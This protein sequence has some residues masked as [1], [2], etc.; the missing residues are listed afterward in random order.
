MDKKDLFKVLQERG[1]IYQAT[2]LEEIEKMLTQDTITAYVGIDPTADSLHIGHCFPLIIARYLQEAGHK[3]FVVL[4]GA[5]AKIGDPSGKST[6]RKMVTDEFVNNNY[7]AIRKII[8][9][10]VDLEGE[11]KATIVNNAEWFRGYDYVNFM[12]DIGVHFNVAH[13]LQSDAYQKRIADGGLTFFEM[14]Y[15]LMQAYDFAYLNRTYGC[16][17]EFGGSDQW[18]NIVAGKEL[19]R[20]LN[21]KEGSVQ[22]P[23]EGFTHPLLTNYEG[24]KMGKTEKGALWVDPNKTSPFEFYQYF[25]NTDDRDCEK[26]MKLLTRLSM[27]EIKSYLSG[28]IRTA[29]KVMA[30]EITKLVHGKIEADKAL[31]LANN[32]FN[33][34]NFGDISHVEAKID[35]EISSLDLIMKTN[36][37]SSKSEARRMIE[38]GAVV[39]DD[40]KISDPFKMF[41]KKDEY[42]VR[43][44][45]KNYI[46]IVNK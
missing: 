23:L 22:K 42:I 20:K 37:F 5:T 39:I 24:V 13:M 34:S 32:I 10:F 12:R 14:G 30:Y 46:K 15:M 3:I 45:K 6:M 19:T 21:Y 9:R 27:D 29:K 40:E 18:A 33:N 17:L 26:L 43:K 1:Y 8:G 2:N 31:E 11:N 38:Q 36:L 16:T 7:E 35:G 4:G 28:D 41:E 25:Y 44:G